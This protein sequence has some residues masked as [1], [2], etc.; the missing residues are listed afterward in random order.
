VTPNP[1]I[2]ADTFAV[3]DQFKLAGSPPADVPYQWVLRRLF[4]GR[5]LDSDKVVTPANGSLKLVELAPNVQQVVGGSANNLI[6]AM[7]DGLGIFD[8]PCC[9]MQSRWVIDAAKAKYPGK[10]IKYLVLT[11]HHMDH[12]GGTRAYVADGATVIVPS[13]AQA[14]FEQ[15][16]ALPH[17]I[18]ADAQQSAKK[19]IQVEGVADE[20]TLKDDSVEIRIQRIA[21]PHV[22]GMLIGYVVQPN[23]VWVTDIW[24]PGRDA[25]KTPGVLALNDAV[26]KLAIKDATFAGGHGSNAKQTVLDGI[27]A[28]N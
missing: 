19:P 15:N 8:A 21:N 1:T 17:T 13:T 28:A 12:T 5:F 22:D 7:N 23:V 24:S 14:Y 26:K 20:K 27:L 18:V 9:E 16:L 2:G 6:V 25:A 10:P 3:A 4:L 11:H